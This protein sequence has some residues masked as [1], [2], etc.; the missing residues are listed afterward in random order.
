MTAGYTTHVPSPA[1]RVAPTEAPAAARLKVFVSYSRKDREIAEELV[2]GLELC[3][4]DAYLD[5]EDIAP[6]EPWEDRL[7]SLIRQSDTVV[8]V[9]SP[10]S[11]ASTHCTWEVDETERLSKRLV[12][13]MFRPVPDADVPTRLRRLNYIFFGEGRSFANG[14]RDLAQALRANLHW[15]REHTRLGDLAARWKERGESAGLLLRAEDIDEARRWLVQRPPDTPEIT[16]QQQAF[17]DASIE[18][19]AEELR[20]RAR[21]QSRAKAATL[22]AAL[23]F[24]V[25][26]AISAAGWWEARR[27]GNALNE[28]VEELRAS[29]L[30]LTRTIAL[31]VAPTGDASYVAGPGW[32]S[33]ATDYA[34]AVAVLKEA[35]HG[36]SS[37]GFLIRGSAL[38]AAWGTEAVL[39]TASFSLRGADRPFHPRDW[40]V[41]FPGLDGKAIGLG[42]PLWES[43]GELDVTVLRVA[44]PLPFAARPIERVRTTA[45]DGL[46][47]LPPGDR[48]RQQPL[49]GR[50]LATVAHGGVSIGYG[51]LLHRLVG[52]EETSAQERPLRL[53]YTHV[54]EPGASGAPVFDIE[55]GELVA[56]HQH[57]SGPGEK[58]GSGASLDAV[59]AAIESDLG[60]N[61]PSARR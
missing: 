2:A 1:S 61:G 35:T 21:L 20:R 31:R 34:G 16:T 51:L 17:I 26:A 42:M 24:A 22:G 41:Q 46:P 10:D 45:F 30:R 59:K 13:V 47:H 37:S 50:G 29:N 48:R 55:T 28:R 58:L 12:P 43:R 5:Q 53:V 40:T 57:R 11:I 25:G 4:F 6:G 19:A 54:T 36:Y 23:I 8:F 3:G 44:G 27:R 39:V 56:I 9:I 14:L 60:T 52:W 33:I 32:Y 49:P 15:I 7:R 18:A 38:H